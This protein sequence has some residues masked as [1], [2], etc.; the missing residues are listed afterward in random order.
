MTIL[1]IILKSYS[2]I[3]IAIGSAALLVFMLGVYLILRL[4][5]EKKP[6]RLS[7]ASTSKKS[8]RSEKI[9]PSE[10]LNHV[11]SISAEDP[12]ATQLDLAKAYIESGKAQLAKVILA[13]VIRHGSTAYQQEAQRLL[14]TI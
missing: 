6:V 7:V 8:K 11:S 1:T 9:T 5:R 4:S 3:L 12:V 13:S 14:S 10:A 2:S